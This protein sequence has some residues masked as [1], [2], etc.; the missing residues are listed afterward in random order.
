MLGFFVLLL[1]YWCF[2][3]ICNVSDEWPQKQGKWANNSL[4][5]LQSFKFC[6]LIRKL[7]KT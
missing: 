3:W 2:I 7:K 5:G 6:R 1:L 4:G